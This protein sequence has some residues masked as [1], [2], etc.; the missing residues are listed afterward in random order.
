MNPADR[1]H[2]LLILAEKDYKDALTYLIRADPM[3][4]DL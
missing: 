4:S 3:P 1:P 2:E